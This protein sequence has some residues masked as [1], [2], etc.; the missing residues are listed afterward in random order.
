MDGRHTTTNERDLF[1]SQQLISIETPSGNSTSSASSASGEN[2]YINRVD[3][4]LCPPKAKVSIA[5]TL[6]QDG[7]PSVSIEPTSKQL[8]S[9]SADLETNGILNSIFLS[10]VAGEVRGKERGMIGSN[11]TLSDQCS[12][13]PSVFLNPTDQPS[14]VIAPCKT[15][16][17]MVMS[18]PTNRPQ[19]SDSVEFDLERLIG[20]IDSSD[21]DTSRSKAHRNDSRI[22]LNE[23]HAGDSAISF[24]TS[25]GNSDLAKSSYSI[26][27]NPIK[28][29][30]NVNTTEELLISHLANSRCVALPDLDHM[31]ISDSILSS[32]LPPEKAVNSKPSS[33]ITALL[34]KPND[35]VVPTTT[36]FSG[37]CS[38]V[39]SSPVV[40]SNHALA[41]VSH[42]PT[43]S[44]HHVDPT[45]NRTAI[46]HPY[47]DAL[48]VQ[49]YRQ[50]QLLNLQLR[51]AAMGATSTFHSQDIAYATS[52]RTTTAEAKTFTTEPTTELFLGLRDVLPYPAIPRS[53]LPSKQ[54][55][56]SVYKVRH[57]KPH[58]GR[59]PT[60]KMTQFAKGVADEVV[61]SNAY[62][63]Q[64]GCRV[65]QKK[66]EEGDPVDI[67]QIFLECLDQLN[68]LMTDPFGNYLCQKLIEVIND[69]Q[70][71]QLLD[72]I[73][74]DIPFISLNMHGTRAT[75]ALVK[76]VSKTERVHAVIDALRGHVV[77]LVK[78]LNGNHV[79]Q[80]CLTTLSN[81]LN[82]FIYDDLIENCV[83]V[84]L[85]RHGCCVLQR[86][87]DSA[88]VEQRDRVIEAIR[89]N[90]LQLVQDAFGNYVVHMCWT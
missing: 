17:G 11:L 29:S 18:F 33:A 63:D 9:A 81:P 88:T 71:G 70:L 79:I 65:L 20:D 39:K 51:M 50:Q 19:D 1:P 75:Q 55:V 6:I 15:P 32:S 28:E 61:R 58:H 53:L 78:D 46:S 60:D 34:G 10:H 41:V 90:T 2:F 77:S 35:S 4:F 26:M 7:L 89:R 82:Q 24:S 73:A 21:D 54:T 84:A 45:R 31:Q 37:T 27:V 85:H 36:S 42:S 43:M 30:P 83:E 38:P 80:K 68:V 57:V 25:E 13:P 67:E 47:E 22:R 76:Q 5:S 56:A 66:L 8:A 12:R 72:R 14:P 69:E 44:K 23:H 74:S 49:E 62:K 52:M 86:S 3:Y 48:L 87:I 64:A 59:A 40:I 16:C